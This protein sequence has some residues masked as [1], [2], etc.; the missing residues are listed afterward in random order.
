MATKSKSNPVVD[1][2]EKSSDELPLLGYTVLWRLSGVQVTHAELEAAMTIAGFEAYMPTPPSPALA[3]DRAIRAWIKEKAQAGVMAPMG[4]LGSATSEVDEDVAGSGKKTRSLL[5]KINYAKSEWLIFNLIL[6]DVDLKALGLDHGSLYRIFLNKKDNRLRVTRTAKGIVSGEEIDEDISLPHVTAGI[7]E[8]WNNYRDVYLPADLGHM[9]K[10]TLK[11]ALGATSLR[12]EGG[13]YFVPESKYSQ[14]EALRRMV[15]SWP[16]PEGKTNKSFILA[17]PVVDGPAARK[18][19]AVATHQAFED[20]LSVM[21]NYL[22]SFLDRATSSK[23]REAS[24]TELL[25]QYKE[26]KARA[27][28]YAD[29]LDMRQERLVETI[30]ELK[31]K[32][33]SSG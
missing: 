3:L 8:H 5:R 25:A 23:I 21:A 13:V 6:E 15:M 31:N 33:R 29:L 11:F 10:T 16:A 24:V 28:I 1:Q 22:Q 17:L 18:S 27:E 30:E 12:A 2:L 19:L 32:A 7:R 4:S 26:I 20:E 9:L 14:L